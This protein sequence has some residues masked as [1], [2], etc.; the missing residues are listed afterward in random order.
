MVSSQVAPWARHQCDQ[1]LEQFVRRV[2]ERN[3]SVAPG[4][5]EPYFETTVLLRD[6][7]IGRDGRPGQVGGHSLQPVAIVCGYPGCALKVVALDLGAQA[8]HEEGIGV[9]SHATDAHD[10]AASAWSGRDHAPS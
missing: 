7:A 2:L 3:C 6:Q 4:P 10:A 1:P 5:F 9:R 8:P